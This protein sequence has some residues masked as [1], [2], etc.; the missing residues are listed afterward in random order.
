MGRIT[1]PNAKVSELNLHYWG[2]GGLDRQTYSQLS[3]FPI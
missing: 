1:W 3:T 2:G